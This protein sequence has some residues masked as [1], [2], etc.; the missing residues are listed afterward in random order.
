MYIVNPKL[1]STQNNQA[2][3]HITITA[4]QQTQAEENQHQTTSS[5]NTTTIAT[6]TILHHYA[7]TMALQQVATIPTTVLPSINNNFPNALKLPKYSSTMSPQTTQTITAQ[8]NA[9]KWLHQNA[10]P[11]QNL[12]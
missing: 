3:Q 8:A 9:S 2:S 6:P 5:N 11:I 4:S 12:Q 7:I 10:S 1:A